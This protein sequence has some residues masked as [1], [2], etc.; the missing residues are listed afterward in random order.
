[1]K[2][3][4]ILILTALL[5][6]MAASCKKSDKSKLP[7]KADKVTAYATIPSFKV[8]FLAMNS[9][10]DL[11]KASEDTQSIQPAQQDIPSRAFTWG[12]LTSKAQLALKGNNGPLLEK[13]IDQ[14]ISI[15]PQIGL[16][17]I[18]KE[19]SEKV[20]PAVGKGDWEF[21][22]T[23]LFSMQSEAE[24]SLLASKQYEIYTLLALGE[25]TEATYC[26]SGIIHSN[27]TTERSTVL[28]QYEAWQNLNANLGLL[29]EGK[30]KDDARIR[31]AGE[32]AASLQNTMVE[33]PD[34]P[35][36][37]EQVTRIRELS[38]ELRE[39]L[40]KPQL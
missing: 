39:M 2:R 9:D 5:A 30:F 28:Q 32:R 12:A 38:A 11:Q 15:A 1:M 3:T 27:Y 22:E 18:A 19:L 21:L 24:K 40:I 29:L 16:A 36:P 25:W 37:P 8:M 26:I 7:D 34:N 31:I 6:F 14:L 20:K 33:E 4:A 10:L 35:L 13:I 17:E 23:S